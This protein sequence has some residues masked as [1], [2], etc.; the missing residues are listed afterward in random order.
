M[1]SKLMGNQ[2]SA[3]SRPEYKDDAKHSVH[4]SAKR[5]W[6]LF[7]EEREMLDKWYV[8]KWN[9]QFF[10]GKLAYYHVLGTDIIEHDNVVYAVHY[11]E[12]YEILVK[13]TDQVMISF[14]RI[15]GQEVGIALVRTANRRKGYHGG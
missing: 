2:N 14:R 15:K 7:A 4:M 10:A 6:Y 11:K 5:D 1:I 12:G 8:L 9:Q 13:Y 3:V